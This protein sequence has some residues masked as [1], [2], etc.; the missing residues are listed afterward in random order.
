MTTNLKSP[1]FKIALSFPGEHRQRVE[2]IAQALAVRLGEES[3]LYD[4]WHR[5]EFARPNLDVYLPELYHKHSLLLVF[6]FCRQ[7]TRK[8]W[9]GLEWRAGRDLLKQGE[10]K[11]IMLLRLDGAGIPGLYSIDGYLDI[12]SVP[13][14]EVI[15]DIFKRLA[16]LMPLP[17][18]DIQSIVKAQRSLV[19]P[20]TPSPI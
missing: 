20:Y 19:L 5:A 12:T 9:C 15:D 18:V 13:D 4:R 11:R 7:F 8:D 16:A 2:K 6:F 3:I 14:D 1:R 17:R 10:D